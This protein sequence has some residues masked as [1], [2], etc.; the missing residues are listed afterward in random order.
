M[1]RS[2]ESK[3]NLMDSGSSRFESVPSTKHDQQNLEVF[4]L[5]DEGPILKKKQFME[6]RLVL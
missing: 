3:K 5:I 1:I 2:M 4:F 6:K